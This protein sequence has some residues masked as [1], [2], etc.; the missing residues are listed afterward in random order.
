MSW[1]KLKCSKTLGVYSQWPCNVRASASYITHEFHGEATWECEKSLYLW[2][3]VPCLLLDFQTVT[4]C[5]L[6]H[7]LKPL[8][9]ILLP[10]SPVSL[11]RF[12]NASFLQIGIGH[13]FHPS[14]LTSCASLQ[15][16]GRSIK[17]WEAR[18]RTCAAHFPCLIQLSMPSLTS[19]IRSPRRFTSSYDYTND[20][21]HHKPIIKVQTRPSCSLHSHISHCTFCDWL[22]M[23]ESNTADFINFSSRWNPT[24]HRKM[25]FIAICDNNLK[26]S[27]QHLQQLTETN[28]LRPI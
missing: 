26:W 20:T 27:V 1:K 17:H 5:R 10:L 14:D 11:S 12:R 15:L 18:C 6:S 24:M 22:P 3:K 21:S 25:V 2:F 8:L 23:P 4:R 7:R 16:R 9:V 13:F 28:A 19:Q